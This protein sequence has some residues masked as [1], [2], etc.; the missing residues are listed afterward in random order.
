MHVG[1]NQQ[2]RG[3]CGREADMAYQDRSKGWGW[4][5]AALK[6]APLRASCDG[7]LIFKKRMSNGTSRF[8]FQLLERTIVHLG[9]FRP[10]V[11]D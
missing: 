6:P 11:D 4:I 9:T 8:H 2:F 3:T 7:Q 5:W 1:Q 10:I